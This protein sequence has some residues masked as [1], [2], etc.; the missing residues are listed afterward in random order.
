MNSL[1]ENSDIETIFKAIPP[2]TEIENGF[3]FLGV[4]L[5][6]KVIDKLQCHICGEWFDSL[7]THVFMAHQMK[8][9]EYKTKFGLPNGYGLVN[10]RISEAFSQRQL[11]E[12]NLTHLSKIRTPTHKKVL[13]T[14]KERSLFVSKARRNSS[15]QNK[16]GVCS[17][18]ILRRYLIV[19]D[20]VGRDPTQKDLIE[21]DESLWRVIRRRHNDSLNEFRRVH[22]FNEIKKFP[23]QDEVKLIAAIR[24]RAN[25]HVPRSSDFR[26]GSPNVCT[27]R[28]YFGS[29]SKAL[30]AAGFDYK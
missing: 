18:Q 17:E 22:G 7:A 10:K 12:K 20:I 29:W 9:R 24:K 13:K 6:N 28:K 14:Y 21:Y 4:I 1:L 15:F 25:G 26:Y 19:A 2:L 23:I 16:L 3:G 5:R 27:I 30:V 11:T 8:S